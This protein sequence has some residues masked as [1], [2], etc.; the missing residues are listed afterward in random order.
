[1]RPCG[2][3]VLDLP[4]CSI[5]PTTVVINSVLS[6]NIDQSRSSCQESKQS[7]KLNILNVWTKAISSPAS[8]FT[9]KRRQEL[10]AKGSLAAQHRI[11]AASP[12]I[13]GNG[14]ILAPT[15]T[16]STS[17]SIPS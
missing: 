13:Q 15:T 11:K 9:D 4:S 3:K 16:P 12:E 10:A 6:R 1:M 5:M 7:I 14:N 2:G 17:A 8:P